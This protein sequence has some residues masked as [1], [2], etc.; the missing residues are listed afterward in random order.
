M[1][2]RGCCEAACPGKRK[3]HLDPEG[4]VDSSPLSGSWI[5][6]DL[7]PV[8]FTAFKPPATVC[9]PFGMKLGQ[10]LPN[11]NHMIAPD[12]SSAC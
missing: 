10:G 1:V 9:H 8:V 5:A 2:A 3:A 12:L 6:G 11:A 7:Y 4:G